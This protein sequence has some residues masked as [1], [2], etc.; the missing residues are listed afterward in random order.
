MRYRSVASNCYRMIPIK[1]L[2]QGK[3]K[4][5]EGPKINR[6]INEICNMN[7]P[8]LK[9]RAGQIRI[10]PETKQKVYFDVPHVG[11]KLLKRDSK[12]H[13]Y[14]NLPKDAEVRLK[15]TLWSDLGGV[16]FV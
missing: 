2:D 9:K 3:K 16:R 4:S 14:V 10:N 1:L 6:I 5:E 15:E 7:G 12:I 8:F 11:L 13:F